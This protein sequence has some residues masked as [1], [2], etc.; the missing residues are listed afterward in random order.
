[1][2]HTILTLPL[3]VACCAALIINARQ[4]TPVTGQDGSKS[5]KVAGQQVP[6]A[7]Q[8]TAPVKQVQQMLRTGHIVTEQTPGVSDAISEGIAL[9]AQVL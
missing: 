4:A 6:T 1:M 5:I 2:L 8:F 7:A 9:V 3:L